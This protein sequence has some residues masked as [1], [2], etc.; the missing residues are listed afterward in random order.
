MEL[1]HS[2][3]PAAIAARLGAGPR[4]S[5]LR[6]VIYGGIDGTVTTFA[7]VAG[8]VGASL[9]ARVVIILGVANLVADGFSMA[10]A[11]YSGTKAEI[12]DT[13]RLRA[14]EERH[15][16]TDPEGERAEIREIFRGKGFEGAD[17]EAIVTLI[18]K[19]REVWIDT[20]LAEEF[21]RGGAV[22]SPMR[23]GLAT[24][25]AFVICGAIPLAPF[26]LGLPSAAETATALT[27][28]VFFAIGSAR[29][30]WSTR[31]WLRCGAETLAIGIA[32]AGAA[33]AVGRVLEG[34]V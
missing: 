22:P 20:M 13:R 2:H 19:R 11:N 25:A 18:T 21:G 9:E 28:A 8:A 14:M 34:L 27:A 32:A 3:T 29:S 1:E 12:E 17:L 7:V 26:V 33:Y 30:R 24:F 23:A 6:D 31:S 15:V 4:V 5:Y 16:A 10:A